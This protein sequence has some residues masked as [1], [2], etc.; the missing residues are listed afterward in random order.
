M[1]IGLETH[2]R[3][4]SEGFRRHIDCCGTE[5]HLKVSVSKVSRKE[6]DALKQQPYYTESQALGLHAE[7][8][9]T[10]AESPYSNKAQGKQGKIKKQSRT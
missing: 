2:M 8:A 4:A 1:K 7:A 6:V 3:L 5:V 9:G 10:P